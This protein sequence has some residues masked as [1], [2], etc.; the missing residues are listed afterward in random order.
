MTGPVLYLTGEYPR[1]TDTFIQ[2]EVTALRAR[3]L[4]VRTASIRRTGAEHLV[5]PEQ[6]GEAAGTF[7]VLEA[8]RN[9]FRLLAAH[10][11]SL[12]M[13]P[14]RYAAAARLAVRTAPPGIT[15]ALKGLAYF[16]EAAVLARHIRRIGAA[17]LHNHIAMASCNVAMLAARMAG[18]PFSFTIHGPDIFF[19]PAHWH[20]REKVAEA[21]FVACISHFCRAQV[22]AFTAPDDWPKLQI[23]R[24]GVQPDAYAADPRPADGILR[25]LF[26]GRLAPVK[27]LPVLLDALRHPAIARAD[28]R[29]DIIGDGPDR[30]RIATRIAAEGL[31]DR[32]TLHGYRSQAEVRQTLRDCDVLV[33]PSFAE[34]VPVVLMEAMATG[35][36]VVATRIAGIP[37]LVEDGTSGFLVPP[38]DAAALARAMASLADADTRAEMGRA[39]ADKVRAG[40][41]V[42]TESAKLMRLFATAGRA[43]DATLAPIAGHAT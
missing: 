41:D 22:M 42:D 14:W 17:H 31:S 13:A 43:S 37:E 12:V 26:V 23:V 5:G 9:P 34:G 33:L 40:F 21:A 35:R 16:V 7:H 39:G 38:G 2:R 15:G 1:A 29:L 4:E 10:L 36:P 8:A 27:G 24:C 20:L 25:L 30:T 32:V 18:V 11:G 3:G 6:R 19:A 28:W